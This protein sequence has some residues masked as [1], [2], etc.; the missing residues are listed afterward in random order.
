MSRPFEETRVKL[1]AARA[2]TDAIL[3]AYSGGKESRC[4]VELCVSVFPK[5]T[6]FFLAPL[7]GLQTTKEHVVDF[8]RARWGLEVR[9]YPHPYTLDNLRNGVYSATRKGIDDVPTLGLRDAYRF[10]AADVGVSLIA[11]GQRK[12]DYLFRASNANNVIE[13]VLPII[14]WNK[15]DV[16]S[17]LKARGI[18]LPASSG[19]QTTGVDLS[20]PSLLWLHDEYPDDFAKLCAV[21][22]FARAVVHRREW[23]GVE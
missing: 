7:P 14:G 22:P 21:F 20:T 4:V 16:M 3:V 15:F 19:R 23:F 17:F 1:D 8:A 18:P 6:L 13:T 2:K 10:A 9:I 12:A 5:V 11:T